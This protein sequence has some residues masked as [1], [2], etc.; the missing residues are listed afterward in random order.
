[1]FIVGL[2]G[3]IGSGKSTIAK[4]FINLGVECIDA[5]E[6]AREVVEPHEPALTLIRE[7][8]GEDSLTQKGEL[9][10]AYI[11][12]R[13]FAA[14]P[15]REWLN[16]LLHPLI[17]ERMILRCQNAKSLY[18]ILMIPLL[19]ENHLE[20]IVN[21]VLVIDTDEQT[22]IQRTMKRDLV[23]ETQVKAIIA[24]Q[25]PRE[26][27][28]QQADDIIVNNNDSSASSLMLQIQNLHEIYQALAHLAK[29]SETK[30]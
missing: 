13:I 4:H 2:T 28:L 23:S 21:R 14:P 6:I 15:E 16:A 30:V 12:E 7:H 29:S 27:R 9:N 17:R 20:S 8:F 3:G 19:F 5:D 24:S 10:R 11:R 1:M 18:C 25:Y 22:Q 26:K